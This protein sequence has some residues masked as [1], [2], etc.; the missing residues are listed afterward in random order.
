LYHARACGRLRDAP[1]CGRVGYV[2]A[3]VSK[4]RPVEQVEEL[5]AKLATQT[6]AERDKLDDGEIHVLLSGATQE[7]SR[8]VAE[9]VQWVERRIVGSANSRAAQERSGDY[10]RARVEVLIQAIGSAARSQD[11]T[12]ECRIEVGALDYVVVRVVND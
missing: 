11:R 9:R 8:R 7:V 4:V 10:E 1:E 12:R 3:G 5:R 2:H 6:L